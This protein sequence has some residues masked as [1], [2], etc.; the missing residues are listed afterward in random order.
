MKPATIIAFAILA[1]L[2]SIG[3]ASAAEPKLGGDYVCKGVSNNGKIYQGTVKI[4]KV[5]AG[6]QV[7]WT[8][9]KQS[10]QGFGLVDDGRFSVT[11][12]IIE[13]KRLTV[14]NVLYKIQK[15]GNLD[16]KWVDPSLKAIYSEHLVPTPDLRTI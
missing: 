7:K 3:S 11:W 6:Y 13:G 5:N 14:G 8:I 1:T 16:G 4:I 10:Y 9:G 2:L 15:N 12:T